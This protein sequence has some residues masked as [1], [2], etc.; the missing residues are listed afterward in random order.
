MT[1]PGKRHLLTLIVWLCILAAALVASGC[2]PFS[3]D[4]K[5]TSSGPKLLTVADLKKYPDRSPE[6]ALL[7]HIFFIQWGSAQNLVAGL[8]PNVTAS[9]GVP[10]I[11][12]GYSFL[13]PSMSASRLRI[14]GKKKT[15]A[16]TLLTFEILPRSGA[17]QPDS[18]LLRKVGKNWIIVYDGLLDR[19]IPGSIFAAASAAPST[20]RSKIRTQ[21]RIDKVLS[22]YHSVAGTRTQI[23][24][25][26]TS[27]R[28]R[29][30]SAASGSSATQQP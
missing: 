23:P 15:S 7:E 21:R 20:K 8:D 5:T 27:R 6:A 22:L 28:S 19:G 10:E 4:S 12:D 14:T 17:A 30:A 24:F 18:V 16:G 11:V 25:R 9:V 26:V 3:E 2:G 1:R 29:E 13:R